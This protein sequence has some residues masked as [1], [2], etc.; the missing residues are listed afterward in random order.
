[1]LK[2]NTM[3]IVHNKG[4][5]SQS[6]KSIVIET[7]LLQKINWSHVLGRFLGKTTK[8]VLWYTHAFT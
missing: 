3:L 7:F 4:G 6:F 1:M 8:Y 2:Y 5:L